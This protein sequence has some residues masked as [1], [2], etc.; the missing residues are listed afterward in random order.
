MWTTSISFWDDLL[1][2][3]KV[4]F[5]GIN[6]Q[7]LINTQYTSVSVKADIY[8]AMKRWLQRRQNASYLR[9]MRAIGGDPITGG[10]YAGDIYFLTNG[11]QIVVNSQVSVVGTI[12]NDTTTSPV[13]IVNAGGVQSTVSNLA[14]AYNTI[15]VT[16]PSA[17]TIADTVWNTSPTNYS[18]D[19]VAGK[20]GK[21]DN[22]QTN[23][24]TIVAVT[25]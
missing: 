2:P 5:D 12:Y 14:Y 21:I 8:S 17:A 16:V 20:I 13:F 3:L 23:V 19:T 24:N 15:P 4:T 9:P 25:S 7:I 11:W 18:T 6:K 10:L 22:I 1:D